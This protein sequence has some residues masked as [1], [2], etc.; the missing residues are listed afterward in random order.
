M[1]DRLSEISQLDPSGW[2]GFAVIAAVI[3]VVSF[4]VLRI[5]A[6]QRRTEPEAQSTGSQTDIDLRQLERRLAVEKAGRDELQIAPELRRAGYYDPKALARFQAIR[7]ALMLIPLFATGF[8]ALAADPSH[9]T[10]VLIYGGIA[11]ALC[12]SLPR[13]YIAVMARSRRRQIERGLPV[14]LDLISLGLLGG[15]NIQSAFQRVAEAVRPTFPV[16]AEEMELVL[17]QAELKTF[18]MALEQWADRSGI[19]E[20]Q[21]LA[22]A[23]SQA[24]RLG[25]DVSNALMELSTNFRTGLRQRADAQANRAS[26]WM[27]FPTILCL[28]IPA[29]IVLMAPVLFEFQDKRAKLKESLKPPGAEGDTYSDRFG[30]ILRREKDKQF[31][32][33]GVRD[34]N[35]VPQPKQGAGAPGL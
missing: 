31:E 20:V 17:R 10:S 23:I 24:D 15:Q 3:G 19:P 32:R 1:L 29:G 21:N 8:L 12:F 13:V 9:L 16:L 11:T 18:P 34:R 2:T 33:P 14:A 30:P 26:V 25:V 27:L 6:P 7:A 22:V 35:A 5:L 28:W 4:V